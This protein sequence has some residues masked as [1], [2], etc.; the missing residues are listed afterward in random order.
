M[1]ELPEGARLAAE[2]LHHLVVLDE[3]LVQD[4]DGHLAAVR[5]PLPAVH[6]GR[7]ALSEGPPEAIATD[8]LVRHQSI[9]SGSSFTPSFV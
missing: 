4:L 2:A 6:H 1:L 9:G 5:D 8:D 3:L 7:G